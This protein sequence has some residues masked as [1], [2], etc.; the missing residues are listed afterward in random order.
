M[1]IIIK[2]QRSLAKQLVPCNLTKRGLRTQKLECQIFYENQITILMCH[3]I[4]FRINKRT[5]FYYTSQ[6]LSK[7]LIL[8]KKKKSDSISQ[9]KTT[10]PL[11]GALLQ[12]LHPA[13]HEDLVHTHRRSLISHK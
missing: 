8:K 2:S 4:N 5:L 7:I 3:V 1:K 6:F 13:R 9:S 11:S 12:L 10:C